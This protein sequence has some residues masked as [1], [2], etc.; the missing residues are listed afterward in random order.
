MVVSYTLLVKVQ[1]LEGEN[2]LECQSP[3]TSP[4]M[5]VYVQV[6]YRVPA[7][8]LGRRSPTTTFLQSSLEPSTFHLDFDLTTTH[9][10]TER[11]LPPPPKG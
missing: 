1:Y 8:Y 10:S 6:P 2:I 3:P 5:E 4:S 7:H 11:S 9:A